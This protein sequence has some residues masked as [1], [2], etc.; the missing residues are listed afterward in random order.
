MNEHDGHE[1]IVVRGTREDGEHVWLMC[2][3]CSEI[4]GKVRLCGR[5]TR[6]G[7]PCRSAV[8]KPNDAACRVHAGT[9]N[10]GE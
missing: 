9:L 4:M 10:D 1:R 5:T 7:K 2:W 3:N 6:K 8:L